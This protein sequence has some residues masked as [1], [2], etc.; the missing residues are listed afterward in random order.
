MKNYLLS[1][2]I[3]LLAACQPSLQQ[4]IGNLHAT[5]RQLGLEASSLLE[6]LVQ[7]RNSINIQ[8]RA[9]MP[10]EIAFTG[11]VNDLEARFRRWEEA[12]KIPGAIRSD[13][14]RL[15]IE[16]MLN[17]QISTFLEDARELSAQPQL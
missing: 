10:E 8:G 5:S 3:L 6:D 13:D 16:K 2:A 9:L 7:L 1:A 12:L 11:K 14:Q 4:R 15:I 17:N